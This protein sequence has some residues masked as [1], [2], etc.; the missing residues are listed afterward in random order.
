[1][2][3]PLQL[4]G[5]IDTVKCPVWVGE[6]ADDIFL[7]EQP[8]KVADALGDK[9]THVVLTD[10]DAAGHHCHIGAMTFLNQQLYDWFEDITK[11]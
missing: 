1:M 7:V 5:V 2:T 11:S 6:A 9:A 3:K 4:E 10:A 8:K